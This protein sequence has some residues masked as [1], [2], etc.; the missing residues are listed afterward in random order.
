M[1]KLCACGCKTTLKPFQRNSTTRGQMKGEYPTYVQGHNH[2]QSRDGGMTCSRGHPKTHLNNRG[3]YTCKICHKANRIARMYNITL[4]EALA[5][6]E[7][8]ELCAAHESESAH[9]TITA[10]H[11]HL[12]LTF[13]GWLCLRCN[14]GL[15]LFRD[16]PDLLRKAAHYLESR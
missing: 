4:E 10:D 14:R 6:P 7:Y 1:K 15:E 3:Y 9:G 13:R 16:D 8:C 2:R 11:C 12:T 5:K